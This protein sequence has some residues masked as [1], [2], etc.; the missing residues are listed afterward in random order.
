MGRLTAP[1]EV[2]LV[3][4]GSSFSFALPAEARGGGHGGSGHGGGH[5]GH[6][7]GGSHSSGSA[8]G[9]AVASHSPGYSHRAH[10]A[11]VHAYGGSY[12]QGAGHS[13]GARGAWSSWRGGWGWR[14]YPA[15]F[16]P[17]YVWPGPTDAVDPEYAD[18]ESAWEDTDALVPAEQ[19]AD[20]TFDVHGDGRALLMDISGLTALDYAEVIFEDG[21]TQVV[22]FRNTTTGPGTYLLLDFDSVRT[23]NNIRL[24][25][26][27]VSPQ[28]KLNI[29][30]AE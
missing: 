25:A 24:V 21:S 1:F 8:S 11:G 26:R 2:A 13:G 19:W 28:V 5:G 15:W 23:V 7:S 18:E 30:L 22:D 9:G 3:I 27:A 29:R 17:L 14:L 6:S 16:L 10:F 4:S 12:Y 20:R